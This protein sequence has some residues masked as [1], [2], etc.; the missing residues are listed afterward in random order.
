MISPKNQKKSLLSVAVIAASFVPTVVFSLEVTAP[1]IEETIV[2]ISRIEQPL[3]DVIG[4]VSQFT[5]EDIRQV[6]PYDLNDMFDLQPGV[7]VLRSGSRGAT[8]SIQI[9]GSSS[10][11]SLIMVN[12]VRIASAT[13]GASTYQLVPPEL[14][15]R[16]EILRGAASALYGSDAIGGVVNITTKAGMMNSKGV[17]LGVDYGSHNYHRTS[18]AGNYAGGTVGIAGAVIRESSDGI[19]SLIHEDVMDPDADAD[20]YERLGGGINLNYRPDDLTEITFLGF[21]NSNDSSYDGGPGTIRDPYQDS[22]LTVYQLSGARRVNEFYKTTLAVGRGTDDS[23][24]RARN[25]SEQFSESI[26]NTT[27]VSV[28]WLNQIDFS[29]QTLVLGFENLTADVESSQVYTN[30]D[31]EAVDSR[32]VDAIFGQLVGEV[33]DFSYA[34]GLR[35]D[36]ANGIGA[37]NSANIGGSYTFVDNHKIH[38]RFAEGFIVPTFNS[39]YYPEYAYQWPLGQYHVYQGNP[40]L[41]PE[42]SDSFEIAYE[43]SFSF[44]SL[45]GAL[46]RKEVTNLIETAY[47]VLEDGTNFSTPSNVREADI[48][49][50]ELVGSVSSDKLGS[51]SAAFDYLDAVDVSESEAQPLNDR[52]KRTLRLTW[53]KT[54]GAVEL[55]VQAKIQSG[56]KVS[57]RYAESGYTAGYGV[58]NAT[59]A[60]QVSDHIRVQAKLNN[61]FDKEYTLNPSYNEDGRNWVAGVKAT[62]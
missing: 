31:G 8:S 4:S 39:A 36:D 24:D 28:S 21:T 54:S 15:G 46:Y 18:V 35:R 59:F 42:Q 16:V 48:Q 22:S 33:S 52:A 40:D 61:I 14:I 12:G 3:D 44:F 51:L 29:G 38:V 55:G 37:E 32:S 47:S 50:V 17:N 58:A 62:F 45:G 60:Y 7:D 19:D 27:N 1:E 57:E 9:R 25:P 5:A 6:Q 41:E 43:G 49:G 10:N 30:R 20:G 11:Q 26:Y 56:R 34:L 53:Q 13:S 2:T 23:V